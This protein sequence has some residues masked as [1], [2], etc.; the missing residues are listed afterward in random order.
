MTDHASGTNGRGDEN[1][2]STLE[3]IKA[4]EAEIQDLARQK[5]EHEEQ[6]RKFMQSE[7]RSAG[8][9]YARE[10]FLHKRDKLRLEVE[11]EMRRKR[12]Q[13]LRLGMEEFI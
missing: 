7:D 1:H 10:I 11:I 8:K 9:F 4:L 2:V 3:K 6:A 13:R 12:I 5:Q